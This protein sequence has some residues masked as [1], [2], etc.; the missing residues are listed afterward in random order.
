[1]KDL[2][3]EDVKV[4]ENLIPKLLENKTKQKFI[5]EA[6]NFIMNRKSKSSDSDASEEDI[7]LNE[8]M[9]P[10]NHSS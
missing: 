6:A 4:M 7:E 10:K 3:K 9:E 1:M 5:L 2:R 8:F